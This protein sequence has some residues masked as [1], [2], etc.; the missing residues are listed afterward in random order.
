MRMTLL[1]CC[2][3]LV[4]VIRNFR[5]KDDVRAGCK[6]CGERQPADFVAHDFH[7]EYTAVGGS[8]RVDLVDRC[9][10]DVDCGLISECEVCSVDIV[11]DRLRQMDDIEAFLTK[12][13]RCLLSA[14]SAE[15][16]NTVKT[17]LVIVLL[18]GFDLVETVLIR[19]SHQLE[20]LAGRSDDRTA[21]CEDAGKV[22]GCKQLVVAVDHTL[23]ALKESVY[24]KI[25]DVVAEAFDDAAHRSVQGLA[26]TAACE[27]SN[28]FHST[29][30]L[31]CSIHDLPAAY[32]YRKSRYFPHFT[33]LNS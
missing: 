8:C 33:R 24:F 16:D 6:T 10:R 7:D 32:E 5:K 25:L 21:A 31:S 22:I 9:R 28:S 30:L 11:V 4:K 26:V 13:V 12:K 20:R 23:V 19:N 17:K 18:H 27:K 3:Y 29:F 1:Y 15:N 14:V 2:T